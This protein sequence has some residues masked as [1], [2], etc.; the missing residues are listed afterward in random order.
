[1]SRYKFLD[2]LALA[3]CDVKMVKKNIR[4]GCGIGALAG[5]FGPL[6]KPLTEVLAEGKSPFAR[7]HLG[8]GACIRNGRCERGEPNYKSFD[9]ITTRAHAFNDVA[10][11]FPNVKFYLSP[12][13]EYGCTD[14]KVV[15]RWFDIIRKEA[16][17]CTPIASAIG[18]WLPPDVQHEYHGKTASGDITSGDGWSNYEG[19][20]ANYA[21]RAKVAAGFWDYIFNLLRKDEKWKPPSQRKSRPTAADI[22]RAMKAMGL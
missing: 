3:S 21:S 16:P 14:K 5:T 8:N 12:F 1:M 7:I 10:I 11:L 18:G 9:V 6:V 22:Q 13:V 4:P 15:N 17:N 2:L 20:F 19:N